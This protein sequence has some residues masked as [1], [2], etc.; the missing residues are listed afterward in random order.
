[1]TSAPTTL[2]EEQDGVMATRPATMPDAA[3]R[4]VALPSRMRSMSS[5]PSIAAAVA[6]VV[7]MNVDAAI[8][9]AWS[10]SPR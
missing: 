10:P 6:I 9:S 1:M 8:P 7:A 3:P 5:Q 4:D 2:T